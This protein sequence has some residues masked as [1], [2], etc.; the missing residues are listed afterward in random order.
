MKR[1]VVQVDNRA[2]V[3]FDAVITDSVGV[4]TSCILPFFSLSFQTPSHPKL[5]STSIDQAPTHLYRSHMVTNLHNH[6]SEHV[7][8]VESGASISATLRALYYLGHAAAYMHPMVDD[9]RY[10]NQ[11]ATRKR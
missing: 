5:P 4:I 6:V 9:A 2:P 7:V 8:I 10:L 11:V 1:S 3:T